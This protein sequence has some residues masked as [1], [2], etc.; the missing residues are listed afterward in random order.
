VE[1]NLLEMSL[2]SWNRTAGGQES[3]VYIRI[4]ER[5]SAPALTVEHV[6]E[7]AGQVRYFGPYLGG[8]RAREAVAALNRV[9]PLAY[10]GTRLRGAQLDMARARGVGPASREMFAGTLCAV[11][12]RQPNAIAQVRGE[13]EQLRDYAAGT[14][15]FERA[16]RIQNEIHALDWV[17]GPQRVTTMDGGH[18]DVYGWSGEVLVRLGVRGGR[19][20]LWSQRRCTRSRATPT[21]PSRRLAGQTLPSATPNSRRRST[22]RPASRHEDFRH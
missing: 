4:D 6:S 19:L 7:P 12:Q 2:P 21:S 5:P 3:I 15:A 18:F 1:R 16:A 9:L 22:S 11:L 17:T 20:C 13:L 14:L 8:L 10:T